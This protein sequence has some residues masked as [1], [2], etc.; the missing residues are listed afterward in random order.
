MGLDMCPEEWIAMVNIGCRPIVNKEWPNELEAWLRCE[1]KLN[2]L[3]KEV[4]SDHNRKV[5]TLVF[6]T[7]E[8]EVLRKLLDY[9]AK[10][11]E[12]KKGRLNYLVD[13]F[14]PSIAIL[15]LREGLGKLM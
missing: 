5:S 13:R 1:K 8:K 15:L 14:G 3:K 6:D 11:H 9:L 10:E 2:A 12:K 4:V 7:E